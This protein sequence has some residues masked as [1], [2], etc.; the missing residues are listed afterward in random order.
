ML[1]K[2]LELE[3]KI[4]L[5]EKEIKVLGEDAEKMKLD[6]EE[7]VDSLR[8]EIE[9]VKMAIQDLVPDFQG[10]FRSSK[11]SVLQ[12]IDPQWIAENEPER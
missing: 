2:E 12:E 1:R 6:L 8:L 10:K 4:N 9:A 3:E 11:K 5:L 7:A